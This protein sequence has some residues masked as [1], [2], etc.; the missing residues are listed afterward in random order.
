M[1]S[2]RFNKLVTSISTRFIKMKPNQLDTYITDA[3]E[4]I[5][6]LAQVD[7]SYVFLFNDELTT[8]TNTHEWCADGISPEIDNL[9]DIPINTYP[10][11]WDHLSQHRVFHIPD[12]TNLPPEAINEKEEFEREHIQSIICVPMEIEGSPIGF[13]GFDAVK[14]KKSW[15]DDDISLLK[16]VGEIFVNAYERKYAQEKIQKQNIFLRSIIDSLTHPFYVIN[17]KDHSIALANKAAGTLPADDTVTC[18]KH[19]H[20]QNSPCTGDNHPCPIREVQKTKKPICVDHQHTT[21][22]GTKRTIA[23]HGYPIFDADGNVEQMIEYTIDIS[24]QRD[25]EIALQKSEELLRLI[26]N[27]TQEAM[28]AID[29]N[30]HITLFNPAAEKMFGRTRTEM[31]GQPLDLLMPEKYRTKHTHYV[32]QYFATGL[33]NMAINRTVELPGHRSDG[34]IFPMEIS[35]ST[36]QQGAKRFVIAVIRDI[37]KK[38]LAKQALKESIEKFR[39]IAELLPVGIFE[40][41]ENGVLTYANRTLIEVAGITPE[42]MKKGIKGVDLIAEEDREAAT[43]NFFNVL[44]GK[45]LGP[46]DYQAITKSGKNIPVTIHSNAINRNGKAVGIRGIIVDISDRLRLEQERLKTEKLESLGILAGGLAHDFNN[47]LTGILG[48]ISLVRYNKS[49]DDKAGKWLEEAEKA[50]I[51]AQ[52]LTQQLLTF[53]KGGNPIKQTTTIDNL[54]KDTVSFVLRGSNVKPVFSIADDLKAVEIDSGQISQVIHNLVLNADQAMPNGGTI[55]VTAQNISQPE[56]NVG[57]DT[58]DFIEITIQDEG[59]GIPKKHLD[60]IFDPYFTTKAKGSGLGLA[61]VYS[62]IK[63]HNGMIKVY[64]EVNKGTTFRILLPATNSTV[65]QQQETTTT[66]PT[67]TG[68]ILVMDDEEIIRNLASKVLTNQGYTVDCVCNGEEAIQCFK[69]VYDSGQRYDAVIL[70]LTIQGGM[71]GKETIK[72]LREI[73]TDIRALVSSGYSNDPIMADYQSFGFDG[74]IPKP[75]RAFELSRAVQELLSHR[76]EPATSLQS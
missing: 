7:R 36:G 63:K 20:N 18:Y 65:V 67:A 26:I 15:T 11:L 38:K 50:A 54:L 52:G 14:T 3:L 8:M 40:T 69:N 43:I 61:T 57:T 10:Y 58:K 13:L 62:I 64:S 39:D 59:M 35:L 71:G 68:R 28:I 32:R 37:S 75:Y 47:L 19:T 22:D 46:N 60:N 56:T 66:L 34:T 51:Q 5:G 6:T 55:T 76:E 44:N 1:S 17:V 24:K 12:I 29:E 72:A 27:A 4:K 49:V 41:D 21:S 30:G 70:D 33:P 53:S 31:I 23:I 73:D 2:Y 74:I 42:D 25:A 16:I 48:N 9:K 45:Y